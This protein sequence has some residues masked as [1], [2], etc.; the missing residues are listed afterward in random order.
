MTSTV[1]I[2]NN[3]LGEPAPTLCFNKRYYG[4]NPHFEI[5]YLENFETFLLLLG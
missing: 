3:F 2:T 1:I 4:Q 5:S